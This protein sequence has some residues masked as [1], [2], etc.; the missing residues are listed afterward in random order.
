MTFAVSIGADPKVLEPR[1]E[2]QTR[3]E[4][5]LRLSLIERLDGVLSDAG[6]RGLLVKGAALAAS[7]YPRPWLREMG[8]VDLLVEPRWKALALAAMSRGGFELVPPPAGRKHSAWLLG[9]RAALL[10]VG[11]SRLTVE[12]HHQLDKVVAR[13]I[14]IGEMLER[15]CPIAGLRALGRPRHE[16]HVLVVVLHAASSDFTHDHA[17]DDLEQLFAADLDLHMIELRAERWRLVTACWVALSTMRARGSSAISAELVDRFRPPG[18]RERLLRRHYR[19][20]S[21]PVAPKGLP[22]GLAWI[23]RQTAL[24][25]DIASWGRGLLRYGEA[26]LRERTR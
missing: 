2:R 19:V 6:V 5:L 1:A 24:R 12:I 11:G 13:P 14:D 3:A 17:W 7:V 15:S 16:D 10:S 18:W 8:D 9:E 21:F 26:R 25:D 20:G 23:W 22:L 4:Y